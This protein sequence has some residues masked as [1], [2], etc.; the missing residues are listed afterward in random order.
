MAAF[1]PGCRSDLPRYLSFKK[2]VPFKYQGFRPESQG[3]EHHLPGRDRMIFYE[4]INVPQNKFQR[5][6]N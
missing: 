2:G 3:R 6:E 5:R 4:A 1:R